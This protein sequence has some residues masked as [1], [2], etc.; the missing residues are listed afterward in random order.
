MTGI[1]TFSSTSEA[2]DAIKADHLCRSI[3]AT[4][5]RYYPNRDWAVDVSLRGGVAKIFCPSISMRHA[6]VVKI[7]KRTTLQIEQAVKH[8]GGEIL[9]RFR[10]SRQRDA[11]GDERHLIRDLRGEVLRAST[12]L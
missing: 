2:M 11:M 10:L 1:V 6:Y 8:A 4:L 9:E 12:G 7:N 3:G 5:K